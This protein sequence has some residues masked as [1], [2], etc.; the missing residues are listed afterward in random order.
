MTITVI[1]TST[2]GTHNIPLS[3]VVAFYAADKYV[4]VHTASSRNLFLAGMRD[5]SQQPVVP[6]ICPHCK[7]AVTTG[8]NIPAFSGD[9]KDITTLLD[10]EQYIAGRSTT[11]LRIHRNCIINMMQV[12]EKDIN[13]V[14]RSL[15][16]PIGPYAVSRRHHA[17]I[18]RAARQDWYKPKKAGGAP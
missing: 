5:D 7:K 13:G 1:A 4:E 16:T 12:T 9:S 15:I 17:I 18:N 11:F 3:N 8:G 6:C 2:K 10:I 14:Q